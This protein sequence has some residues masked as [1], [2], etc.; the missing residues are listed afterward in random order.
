VK[1]YIV[2]L[3][4]LIPVIPAA[5]ADGRPL[6]EVKVDIGPFFVPLF[7]EDF[8]DK[9]YA[10]T[11]GF[12]FKLGYDRMLS[13][14]F[15]VGAEFAFVTTKIKDID[16]RYEAKFSGID[17]GIHCRFYPWKKRFYLEGGFGLVSFDF[18]LTGNGGL[19]DFLD[20]LGP[21]NGAAGTLDF[22]LGWRLILGRHFIIDLS[23][24]YGFYLGNSFSATTLFK[25]AGGAMAA[26]LD[27]R[28]YTHRFDAALALGW[29]F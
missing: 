8:M 25:L 11:S 21:Y 23:L 4:L 9:I 29:A 10:E 6:N 13:E 24:M 17:T 26:F 7:F 20:Y 19:D 2:F 1:K 14:R 27:D 12:G 16:D 28:N 18:E 22:G 3:F 15:S 5:A